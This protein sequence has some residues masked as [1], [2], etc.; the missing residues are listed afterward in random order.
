MFARYTHAMALPRN[1]IF[2]GYNNIHILY[3]LHMQAF[4]FLSLWPATRD[5]H[6]VY[7]VIIYLFKGSGNTA[8]VFKVFHPAALLW[9]HSILTDR[10]L[11]WKK[12]ETIRVYCIRVKR[13]M[14]I[15]MTLV[16]YRNK[17]NSN[18]RVLC[19][20]LSVP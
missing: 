19:L 14:I 12:I 18:G 11:L 13:V 8:E 2:I 20:S 17:T 9:V 4:V 6:Q 5:L 15:I 1:A 16:L 10:K 7:T 3:L